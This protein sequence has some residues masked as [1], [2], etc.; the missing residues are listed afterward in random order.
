MQDVAAAAA[1]AA[2]TIEAAAVMCERCYGVEVQRARQGR[3][4][5]RGRFFGQGFHWRRRRR[6]WLD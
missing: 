2:V 5:L 6:W 4:E 3:A 1:A